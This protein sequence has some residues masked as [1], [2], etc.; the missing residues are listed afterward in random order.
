[1]TSVK[2]H[3]ESLGCFWNTKVRIGD[4]AFMDYEDSILGTG[5]A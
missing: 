1:M 3:W 5:E 2:A 4:Y